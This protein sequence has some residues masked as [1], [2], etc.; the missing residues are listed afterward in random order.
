MLPSTKRSVS[1]SASSRISWLNP[2]PH[3]LVVYASPQPSPTDVQHSLPGG[4][5][6]LPGRDFHPL[7]HA[8]FSWRTRFSSR[9]SQ[10]RRCYA[11]ALHPSI[12]AL[13]KAVSNYQVCADVAARNPKRKSSPK[14]QK[15]LTGF[16]GGRVLRV[17]NELS[18]FVNAFQSICRPSAPWMGEN[19]AKPSRRSR[20]SR[21]ILLILQYS[22]T[23]WNPIRAAQNSAPGIVR[24][25]GPL[26]AAPEPYEGPKLWLLSGPG[27]S[28]KTLM[29]R[30]MG[31]ADGANCQ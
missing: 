8:S 29:A 16:Q 25:V 13:G 26:V 19:A 24:E 2:A 11:A 27:S 3:A 23:P 10:I 21:L 15:A 20:F 12:Q 4:R 18:A 22:L 9:N 1:A 28:G 7:E 6:P 14:A 5:Y 30:W 31:L 17:F